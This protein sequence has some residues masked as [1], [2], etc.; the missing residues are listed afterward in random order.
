LSTAHHCFGPPGKDCDCPPEREFQQQRNNI[1]GSHE[2]PSNSPTVH[3]SAVLS[4]RLDSVTVLTQEVKTLR[5]ENVEIPTHVQSAPR[6]PPPPPNAAMTQ[7]VTLQE[8]CAMQELNAQVNSRVAQPQLD[9][10]DDETLPPRAA[11]SNSS[12][13]KRERRISQHL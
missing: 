5:A 1:A 9:D 7:Q 11:A 4:G 10:S 3:S 12:K 2:N 13:L 6:Q 8:L